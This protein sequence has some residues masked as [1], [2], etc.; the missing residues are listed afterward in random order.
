M[1]QRCRLK[2]KPHAIYKRDV[3]DFK[4]TPITTHNIPLG[5]NIKCREFSFQSCL[6]AITIHQ[7][8]G[9]SFDRVV[10][11][12]DK[13]QQY[14]LVCMA[15][16]PCIQSGINY[17]Q[18]NT[19]RV[20]ATGP[21][22]TSSVNLFPIRITVYINH[23]QIWLLGSQR[24][25]ERGFRAETLSS[26]HIVLP[27]S[28]DDSQLHHRRYHHPVAATVV[29]YH[30]SSYYNN[31]VTSK[32]RLKME[33]PT[34]DGV[35]LVDVTINIVSKFILGRVSFYP[36]TALADAYSK[37]II[38]IILDYEADLATPIIIT[39]DFNVIVLQ[40]H[41]LLDFI[42]YQNFSKD[43]RQ[44]L[45][46]FNVHQISLSILYVTCIL[47]YISETYHQ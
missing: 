5:S 34:V 18:R 3:L 10:Y 37:G 2:V 41:S 28:A 44:Y 29:I 32:I 19:R 46:W 22:P 31:N 6:R 33:N 26:N 12:Y 21:T 11:Q 45:Y 8:P 25:M 47:L 13:A 27:L 17:S 43:F 42:L 15:I 16:L 9:G 39:G 30:I 4:W 24:N 23:Q 20:P 7:S 1:D 35:T 14:Q 40:D 38:K 36:V